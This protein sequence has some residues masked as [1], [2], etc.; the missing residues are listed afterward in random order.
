[1]K[2]ILQIL[3]I[4]L[5][6]ANDRAVVLREDEESARRPTDGNADSQFAFAIVG[7][8]DD[9]FVAQIVEIGGAGVFEIV[10]TKTPRKMS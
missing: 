9:A 4:R 1:M 10:S 7:E 3:V 8:D 6:S 5:Q 2:Q